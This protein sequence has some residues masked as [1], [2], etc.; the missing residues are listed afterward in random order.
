MLKSLLM[1][2]KD[3][4]SN[5]QKKDHVCHW[6]CQADGC[7]FSYVGETSHSLR[8]R[9]KEHAKSTTSAIHKH[10]TDFH[11]PLALSHQL[12][13]NRQGPLSGHLRS[14]RSHTYSKTVPRYQ[15]EYL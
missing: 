12:C 1:H 9:A 6:Q 8:E 2:S 4:V 13:N 15:K 5:N 7:K 3:K 11:H 10:C 14:Q